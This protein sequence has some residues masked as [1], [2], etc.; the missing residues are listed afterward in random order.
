MGKEMTQEKKKDFFYVKLYFCTANAEKNKVLCLPFPYP[1]YVH[2]GQNK[3]AK[4][5][6]IQ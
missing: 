1:P 4:S 3:V 2:T 5:L 6:Y